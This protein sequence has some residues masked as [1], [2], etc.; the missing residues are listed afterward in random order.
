MRIKLLMKKLRFLLNVKE[1]VHK[2]DVQK[3]HEKRMAMSAIA[4]KTYKT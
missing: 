2:T 4:H 3:R 1:T